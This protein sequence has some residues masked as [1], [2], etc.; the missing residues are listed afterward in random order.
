M[1]SVCDAVSRHGG[2]LSVGAP[3]HRLPALGRPSSR[4]AGRP[5][6][7]VQLRVP[8]FNTWHRDSRTA[9]LALALHDLSQ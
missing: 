2:L 9:R 4:Q 5:P 3:T 6:E 1:H 7:D 8:F